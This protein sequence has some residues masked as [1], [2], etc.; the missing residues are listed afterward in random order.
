MSVLD[1]K[2]YYLMP[3]YPMMYAGGALLI[4][5]SSTS[6]K[7]ISRWFGSRPYIATL[8]IVAILLSPIA[9]PILSPSTLVSKYGTSAYESGPLPDKVGWSMMVAN[10]SQAYNALPATE[11]SHACI[12]TENYGE[13]S[14]INFLGKSLGLPDAIS[15]HNNYY[16]WGPGSCTGRVI[17]TVGYSLS[18]DQKS[19]SNVTLLTT[20][21]CKYCISY[22]SNLPVYLCTNPNFT[23]LS[24]EWPLVRHYD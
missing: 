2:T 14:A 6:K 4:E 23:S 12:F 18:D 7:G 17:I 22:E 19:F 1:M 21:N 13:A 3:I 9:M 20:I 15:G 5:R 8:V 16:I 10:L 11:R 24:A